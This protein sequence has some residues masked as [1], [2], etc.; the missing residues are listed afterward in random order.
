VFL[1]AG[2]HRLLLLRPLIRCHALR[3]GNN[4][5]RN[6]HKSRNKTRNRNKDE[7]RNRTHE[8]ETLKEIILEEMVAKERP[9]CR[10]FS[11][12]HHGPRYVF[13][14]QREVAVYLV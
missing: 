12:N 8:A 1:I 9:R 11:K 13:G 5:N 4:K 6:R 3:G 10:A 14:S 7:R 2:I